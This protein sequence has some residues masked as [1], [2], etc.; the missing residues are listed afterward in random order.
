VHGA[1][2][3]FEVAQ[4]G[5]QAP[6]VNVNG[7]SAAEVVIAPNLAE[8]LVASEYS[9]RMLHQKLEQREFFEG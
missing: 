9:A 5:A 2:K 8:Q 3:R 7:S 6:D 1:D 4:L